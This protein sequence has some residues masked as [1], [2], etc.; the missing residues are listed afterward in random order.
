MARVTTNVRVQ[1]LIEVDPG[2][3]WGEECSIKQVEKQASESAIRKIERA[4]KPT[5][6]RFAG[7][8]KVTMVFIK[9]D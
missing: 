5:Q 2:E 9:G 8:P 4:M 6:F 7:E 1:I 3:S